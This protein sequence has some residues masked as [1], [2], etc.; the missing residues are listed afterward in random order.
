[1]KKATQSPYEQR[2]LDAAQLENHAEPVCPDGF[3]CRE[4]EW[5]AALLATWEAKGRDERAL[6]WI[7]EERWHHKATN[8]ILS[9]GGLDEFLKL[10]KLRRGGMLHAKLLAIIRARLEELSNGK[11]N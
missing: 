8:R 4:C 1:V 6:E 11:A 2:H 7:A 3:T 10:A 5:L 9:E